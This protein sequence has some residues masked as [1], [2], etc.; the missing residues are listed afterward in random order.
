MKKH[1]ENGL[2]KLIRVGK[3]IRLKWV[4][5]HVV[6]EYDQKIPQS[7]TADYPVAPR[8]RATFAFE[9][10]HLIWL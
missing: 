10:D 8:G 1:H 6:S 2:V 9:E 7:Q 3:S 5:V 4:N